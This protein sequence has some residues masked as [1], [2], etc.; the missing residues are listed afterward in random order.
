MILQFA[1]KIIVNETVICPAL[2]LILTY[3]LGG[4]CVNRDCV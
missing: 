2:I 3:Y 4:R 1:H